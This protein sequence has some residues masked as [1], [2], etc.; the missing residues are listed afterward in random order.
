MASFDSNA[1]RAAWRH[2]H[3]RRSDSTNRTRLTLGFV[4]SMRPPIKADKRRSPEG[5]IASSD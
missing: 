1:D 5:M 4:R 2:L 3:R